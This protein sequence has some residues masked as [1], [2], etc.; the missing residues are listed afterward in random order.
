MLPCYLKYFSNNIYVLK[1]EHKD[2]H[3]CVSNS[4][5]VMLADKCM[6]CQLAKKNKREKRIDIK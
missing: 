6:K 5:E 3:A 1:Y 4:L 2:A